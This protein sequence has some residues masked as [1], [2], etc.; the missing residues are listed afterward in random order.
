ML[1]RHSGLTQGLA[2]DQ[3][4]LLLEVLSASE[5]GQEMGDDTP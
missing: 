3:G 2:Q 1:G 4:A 5:V